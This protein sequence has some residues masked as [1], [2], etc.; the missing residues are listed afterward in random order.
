LNEAPPST[1][2]PPQ[3]IWKRPLKAKDYWSV[4]VLAI[5]G[6][7]W[8]GAFNPSTSTPQATSP[9][10][11]PTSQPQSTPA[12]NSAAVAPTSSHAR[13]A[14]ANLDPSRPSPS[15]LPERVVFKITAADLY[16]RYAE[17]E[18]KTDQQI[19]GAIVEVSGRIEA[20]DKDVFDDPEIK[21]ETG[22]DLESVLTTLDKDQLARA[23]NLVRGQQITLR[24]GKMSRA[25]DTPIGLHCKIVDQE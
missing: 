6:A 11:V 21:L 25:I 20:I 16:H 13:T 18:V 12:D 2:S 24:C 22:E 4:A 5:F 15:P 14:R 9:D 19:A 7:W 1:P 23:A 3:G 17:N 10:P 8:A